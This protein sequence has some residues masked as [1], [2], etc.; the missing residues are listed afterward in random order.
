M[1]DTQN[2]FATEG[3]LELDLEQLTDSGLFSEDLVKLL[4]AIYGNMQQE[5]PLLTSDSG[6][7]SRVSMS[8]SNS[9]MSPENLE[10]KSGASAKFL[11]ECYS[12]ETKAAGASLKFL[13]ECYGESFQTKRGASL[14]FMQ[15]CYS[16][17]VADTL[18][19]Y[20]ILRRGMRSPTPFQQRLK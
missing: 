10:I 19:P 17:E 2:I 16:G 15:E 20:G 6:A 1:Q 8:T 11:Q 13:E 3:D 7:S 12:M 9:S 5:Q 4:A 18:D 14:K